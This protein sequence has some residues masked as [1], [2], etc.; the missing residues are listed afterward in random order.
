MNKNNLLLPSLVLGISFI[1]CA[2][3]LTLFLK[4][5][6]Q[7]NQTINVTGSAKREITSDL[8]I[9]RSSIQASAPTADAAY[10]R[11]LE[12]RPAVLSYLKEKGFP[13]TA[14]NLNTI[15]LNPV[16]EITSQ[17]Y[18]TSHI[19]QYNAN[20]MVEVTSADVQKIKEVSLDMTSLV[21]KG[22]DINVM[23]PEYYFTKLAD[24]KIE[25]QADA[26]KDAL[27]RAQ[28]I[29]EATGSDLGAI[30]NARMGVIQI[31]PANSNMISDYGIN[32]ATSIDKEITAVVSASFRLE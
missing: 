5:R 21:N 24:L 20:Q 22:I 31:T 11:L 10:Q 17:G 30:T 32:D 8:G 29:A 16:Y 19:I 26:A 9:L 4:S 13:D 15:N 2:L 12:Q 28:K 7:A 6:D 1:V 25:I 3:L 18:S 23:P 14:I 27:H